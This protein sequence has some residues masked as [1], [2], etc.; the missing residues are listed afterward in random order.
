MGQAANA[1]PWVGHLGAGMAF[2]L[3]G[4][5]LHTTQTVGL[6]LAT[7]LAPPERQPQVVGL[8][9]VMQ[10]IGMIGSALVLKAELFVT[11]DQRQLVAAQS[12][13]LRAVSV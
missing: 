13:G 2:L 11:S 4:A 9:Y 12:C 6:A 10:L 8:M 3:V 5:G 1:P 7:D